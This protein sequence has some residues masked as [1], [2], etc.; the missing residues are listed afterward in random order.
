MNCLCKILLQ[1]NPIWL[2]FFQSSALY[3][4]LNCAVTIWH[5]T[6]KPLNESNHDDI[7]PVVINMMYDDTH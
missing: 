4:I 7:L 5:W 1:D 3:A 2:V 6:T